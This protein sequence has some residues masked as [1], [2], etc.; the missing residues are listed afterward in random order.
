[1]ADGHVFPDNGRDVFAAHERAGGVDGAVVLHVAVIP[2]KNRADVAAQHG[3]VPD[4]H[5]VAKLHVSNDLAA[6]R[7]NTSFPRRV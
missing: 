4:A 7:E 2:D 6:R 1:V 5:P 3:V